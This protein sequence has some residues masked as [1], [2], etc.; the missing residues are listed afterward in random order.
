MVKKQPE[1]L[2]INRRARH[3]YDVRDEFNVGIALTGQEVKAVRTGQAQ[4]KGAYVTIKDGELWLINASF[5]ITHSKPGGSERTVETGPRKLLAKKKEIAQLMEAKD[6][7]LTIVP[8]TMTTRTRFIKLKIATAKGKKLYDKRQA[9]K[10][11]DIERE[12]KRVLAHK[13]AN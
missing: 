10:Q 5:S 12:N 2:I 8:L 11:R 4:L 9:I 13:G 7:G 3:D 6:Q 1:A